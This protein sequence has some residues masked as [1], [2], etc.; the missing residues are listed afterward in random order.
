MSSSFTGRKC[1][2]SPHALATGTGRTWLSYRHTRT[3]GLT[4]RRKARMKFIQQSLIRVTTRTHTHK[5]TSEI[6]STLPIFIILQLCMC[7]TFLL[8]QIKHC[9]LD[10]EAFSKNKKTGWS[11]AGLL[12]LK[13]AGPPSTPA[14]CSDDKKPSMTPNKAKKGAGTNPSQKY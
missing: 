7:K 6:T 1:C 5:N 9:S 3:H 2:W 14:V 11:A 8:S 10:A 4:S 13:L 12:C